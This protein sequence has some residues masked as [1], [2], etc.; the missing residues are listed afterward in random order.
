MPIMSVQVV[1]QTSY[2][3]IIDVSQRPSYLQ[4][5]VSSNIFSRPS[6]N[7]SSALSALS[8][9]FLT[10]TLRYLASSPRATWLPAALEPRYGGLFLRPSR[11]LV[12]SSRSFSSLLRALFTSRRSPLV[13][14][15]ELNVGLREA[16]EPAAAITPLL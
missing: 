1:F 8:S 12:D 16:P 6:L 14:D 3:L 15:W 5:D 7:S 9:R 4:L 10:W 13:G 2:D 11:G